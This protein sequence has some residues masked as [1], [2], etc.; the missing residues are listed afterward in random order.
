MHTT[1]GLEHA[2]TVDHSVHQLKEK[3]HKKGNNN[4]NNNKGLQRRRKKKRKMRQ[5][6][7]PYDTN[8]PHH[9]QTIISQLFSKGHTNKA[10]SQRDWRLYGSKT[11]TRQ[12][13]PE[14]WTKEKTEEI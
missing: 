3:Y 13:E 11:M 8:Y 2:E 4:N 6:P 5:T 10:I 7:W 14:D 9:Q 1:V 12:K